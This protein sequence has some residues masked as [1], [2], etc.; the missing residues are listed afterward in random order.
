LCGNYYDSSAVGARSAS[1]EVGLWYGSCDSIDSGSTSVGLTDMGGNTHF[2]S[3][4]GTVC[5]ELTVTPEIVLA[6]CSKFLVVGFKGNG[7]DAFDARV[8]W[9]LRYN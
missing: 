8:T 7:G 4:Q 5:F 9:S 3:G 1:L 6:A 2:L